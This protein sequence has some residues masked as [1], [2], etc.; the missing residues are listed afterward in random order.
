MFMVKLTTHKIHI[1][2]Q[3]VHLLLITFP[4]SRKLITFRCK[5]LSIMIDDLKMFL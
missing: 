5:Q 3:K 1:Q 4:I 2:S